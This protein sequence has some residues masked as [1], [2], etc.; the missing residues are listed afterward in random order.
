MA[1]SHW[2]FLPQDSFGSLPD[3]ILVQSGDIVVLKGLRL[4][5]DFYAAPFLALWLVVI[6]SFLPCLLVSLLWVGGWG[7]GFLAWFRT[8]PERQGIND[9]INKHDCFSLSPLLPCAQTRCSG[10]PRQPSQLLR[11]YWWWH[12]CCYRI[13]GQF[14]QNLELIWQPKRKDRH[15]HLLHWDLERS[16][17]Q[18]IAVK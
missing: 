9:I 12:G 3:I 18:P 8:E 6:C 13:L 17:L 11:S 16:M 10:W 7:V 15:A 2:N 14:S 4:K 1:H 5:S